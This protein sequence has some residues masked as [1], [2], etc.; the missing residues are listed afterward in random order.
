MKRF[1]LIGYFVLFAIL[2]A[3]NQGETPEE[4]AYVDNFE[5][6][7][8]EKEQLLE[9]SDTIYNSVDRN[10]E[11][12][13]TVSS[14]IPDAHD[15][16]TVNEGRYTIAGYGAGNV[17]IHD[18]EDELL[19]H[20]VLGPNGVESLTVDLSEDHTIKVDGFENIS[21]MP[22]EDDLQENMLASGI[23]EVGLDIDEGTYEAVGQGGSGYLQIFSQDGNDRVYEVVD[24][25]YVSTNPTVELRE[26][27]KVK[28]TSIPLIQFQ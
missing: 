11:E 19:I 15:Y 6:I 17:Y 2:A 1:Q 7:G 18:S 5:I 10:N 12:A 21:V 13:E 24:G 23:W 27:E 3:C 26:G 25:P 22:A 9:I 28:I 14:K 16:L 4:K 20:D 8:E